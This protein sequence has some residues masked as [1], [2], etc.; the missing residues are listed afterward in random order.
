M[1][2][3]TWLEKIKKAHVVIGFMVLLASAASPFVVKID[4]RWAKAEATFDSIQQVYQHSLATAK[5][6]DVKIAED[7]VDKASSDKT[8]FEL[9][10]GLDSTKYSDAEGALYIRIIKA[11]EKA[12]IEYELALQ[13][14]PIVPLDPIE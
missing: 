7:K 8:S 10:Y 13:G 4:H 12:S 9:K 1:K 11:W 3:P 14:E 6:V 2:K 5:R